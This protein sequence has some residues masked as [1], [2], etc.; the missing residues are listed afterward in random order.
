MGGWA[1]F[2]TA[3]GTCGLAWVAGR[4]T[5]VELPE[6][7]PGRLSRAAGGAG[8]AEPPP[9]VREVVAAMTAELAGSPADLSA[10]PLDTTGISA[11]DLAV[12]EV[13]RQIPYGSTR[14]YG[15]VAAQL[16]RPGAAQAVGQ[17]LGRNPLP[18]LIPCHR[19]L[20]AGGAIGGFS[21][22]GGARTK[23]AML[24]AEGAPGFQTLF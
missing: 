7:W 24:E 11:F 5:R 21:A 19:V 17:A 15:A 6:V 9:G 20:A 4:V 22:G 8:A 13:T 1:L 3:V 23:R 16:G 12:Y 14:T 2:D 10:V 18:I